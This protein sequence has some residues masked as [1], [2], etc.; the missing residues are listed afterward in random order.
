MRARVL[1]RRVMQA[2]A[3]GV[4]VS[5]GVAVLSQIGALAGWET[6]AIDAFLFFRDRVAVPD[7]VLVVIDE[8]DFH[9]LGNRQPL[10]REYLATLAGLLLDS[11]ASVVAL[12]F[13][14]R[15]PESAKG[16]EVL[17]SLAERWAVSRA[18]R[19]VFATEAI[20][21]GSGTSL[22]YKLV[23]FFAPM[24]GLVGFANA[25]AGADGVIR[26]MTP[27]LPAS[28][29]GML[30]SL[31]LAV[32]A[33]YSGY[34]TDDFTQVLRSGSPLL[35]PAYDRDGQISKREPLSVSA[36]TRAAW[37]IDFAGPQ[38]SFSNFGSG[39]LVAMAR[40]GVRPDVS[41]PFRG[42]IV[43]VGA[44]FRESR[45]FYATP[46]GLMAGVEIHANMINTLLSR[47]ALQPPPFL[48]N[49]LVL[50]VSCFVVAVLSLW[51]R[52]A[53]VAAIG[54]ALVAAYVAL[55]YEAYT[56]GGYWLDFVAPLV[57]MLGYLQGGR[58]LA[59]RR[60]RHAFG[61][62]V[63]PDVMNRVLAEGARLG[64]ETRTVSVLMS[65]LRGFTAMAEQRAP[66]EV[67]ETMNE[68]FTAMVDVIL[69]HQGMI[70]DFIGDG[71]L[72]IFGAPVEDP[73]HARKAV[74]A[75]LAMQEAF[76]YLN[77][78]WAIAGRAPMQMGVAVH[79]G[80]VFAGYVGSPRRKKYAVLG[81]TV[82]TVSRLEGLNRELGTA[83]LVSG[84][85]LDFVGRQVKVLPRGA[86]AVKGRAQPVD[87]FELLG[88][89]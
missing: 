20:P 2:L 21:E 39:P 62:F 54:G 10:S 70:Q 36:L 17:A 89:G 5:V 44:T 46:V 71:M 14:L 52:P 22:G 67:S 24:P 81:D 51:L 8:Q 40:R 65:D 68:Y 42:R 31:P 3:L 11:G 29:G 49:M 85:A 77:G 38:G 23:P 48:L 15:T 66:A 34:S 37:R 69:K 50:T 12:D 9:D 76:A 30:P 18:A 13:Q 43:L 32:L 27:A 53:W 87:V 55:S 1:P 73:Q 7:I 72:A 26:R 64:G 47:R 6:R 45:D 79:S 25:P 56:Q 59:R 84:A 33:A 83:I 86:V 78:Q 19:P 35:L 4:V 16:D 60:L 58:F 61:E 28:D 63:S 75:A 82:N 41:N 57:G 88:A 74:E 80:P